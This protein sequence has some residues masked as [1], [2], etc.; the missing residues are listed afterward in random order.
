MK[1][2]VAGAGVSGLVAAY[3][4]SRRHDVRL[5]EAGRR[6]GGHAHTVEVEEDGRRL[7]VDTGFIVF[8]EPNY[9][10]LCRLFDELG[11][12]SRASDMSFSVHCERSGLEYN[13]RD[14]K[15]IFVQRK[16]LLS[17][18]HWR[19]LAGIVRF[20]RDAPAHL[21]EGLP[22]TVTVREYA[23]LHRFDGAFLDH[24]LVPLGAALWSCGARRFLEFPMRF[25]IEFLLNHSMLKL[26]ARPVWRTVKGGSRQYVRRLAQR[27]G[28]RCSLGRKVVRVE[29]T[30]TGCARTGARAGDRPGVRIWLAGG[31]HHDFDEAVLAC[32]AD[33]SLR[34]LDDPDP[35]EREVLACFP[36]QPNRAVLHTDE[37]MLPERRAARASWNYRIP[38]APSAPVTVTYDLS[39]LQGLDSRLTYCVTLNPSMPIDEARVI[40]R[41][42]YRHPR[43]MPGREAAQAEHAAMTRRRGISYCGAYWGYGFHEDGVRSALA[44]CRAFGAAAGE[45]APAS[46]PA[47]AAA[48]DPAP[49]PVPGPVA[50]P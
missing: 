2:A 24:Y 15:R 11:V 45:P 12:E 29:R 7:A 23:A 26:G 13:G 49:A 34:L 27:L 14:L 22:D 33:E 46:D 41:L 10:N 18:R 35:L 1:I 19:M 21:R 4:L 43:F 25:V 5:F 3:L 48:F 37:G 42:D 32:H 38:R 20:H 28:A 47:S 44:V 9:P 6:P 30:V 8:N 50:A 17:A 39:R 31:E 36:Y 40:R 16:N